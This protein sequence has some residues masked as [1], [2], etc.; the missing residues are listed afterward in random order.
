MSASVVVLI[1]LDL[2]HLLEVFSPTI[3]QVQGGCAK[4]QLKSC[5][6]TT[7]HKQKGS[8]ARKTRVIYILLKL[9]SLSLSPL[10]CLLTL[11]CHLGRPYSR[12]SAARRGRE[13]GQVL[14]SPIQ[15]SAWQWCRTPRSSCLAASTVK[16][17][18]WHDMAW[19]LWI[20]PRR[21]GGET[22]RRPGRT[23]RQDRR[24][25]K[26]RR[27]GRGREQ[28][29]WR[30]GF[31]FCFFPSVLVMCAG[32]PDGPPWIFTPT[33]PTFSVPTHR[34]PFRAAI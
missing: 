21:A 6:Q 11:I 3:S 8:T 32:A 13:R 2:L 34:T 1:Q 20:C 24:K 27:R 14:G 7:P 4:E 5:L 30:T 9:M 28:G 22:R 19:S 18:A 25:R 23:R 17:V 29:G 10:Q 15:W 31:C 26:K 12:T 16:I 33:L